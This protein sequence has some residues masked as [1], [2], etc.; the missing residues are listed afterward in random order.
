[1]IC[2]FYMDEQK[3]SHQM[4][5][6]YMELYQWNPPN[7]ISRFSRL[8]KYSNELPHFAMH[9]HTILRRQVH[10]Y[11]HSLQIYVLYIYTFIYTV[12]KYPCKDVQGLERGQAAGPGLLFWI[13]WTTTFNNVE[14]S[15]IGEHL[16]LTCLPAY[17][18]GRIC[19]L[20][21]DFDK[22]QS[23]TALELTWVPGFSW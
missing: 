21:L 18:I 1:M 11:A 14:W 13:C 2:V 5:S 9:R 19:P 12:H 3:E 8:G 22:S 17:W 4:R 6:P 10:M 20:L 16:T 23:S 7:L 15:I